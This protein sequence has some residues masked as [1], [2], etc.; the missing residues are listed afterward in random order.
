MPD[1]SLV[2]LRSLLD[3]L[4][5]G[6]LGPADLD[7][8][9]AGP[10]DPTALAG[11]ARFSTERYQR[12]SLYA[13][14]RVE[15]RLLCWGP[16]QSSALHGH[17]GSACAFRVVSGVAEEHLL[18]GALTALSPGAIGKVEQDTI[19]QVA[20]RGQAPL[21]TLHA[22][23]PPLPVDQPAAAD[24]HQVV[25]VGGGLAGVSV[26]VHLLLA[27]GPR[28]RVTLVDPGHEIGR[29]VAYAT[30][31]P[32][33]LLNVPSGKMAIHPD[34]PNA[35]V[36]FALAQGLTA[37]PYTLL[38]RRVYGAYVQQALADA[39]CGAKGRLRLAR[40]AAHTA[41]PSGEGWELRL[42][43]G[44]SLY[45]DDLV[46]ATGHAA[47]RVPAGL[48]ALRGAPGL[49]E[50]PWAPGAIASV[51]ADARVLVVGTGLSAMDVVGSLR[52]QGHRAPVTATSRRGQ[53]PRPHLPD[54]HWTGV[55]IDLDLDAAPATA[56]GLARWL[57]GE[58]KSAATRGIPWQAVLGAVRPHV[59]GL[60]ASLSEAE[61][62][63]FL[64]RHRPRW[65][66]YRHRAP[67]EAHEALRSWRAEGWLR[68][69]AGTLLS[70]TPGPDGLQVIS[71]VGAVVV[72]E[73][74]DY[75]ILCTGNEGEQRAHSP[76]WA[77]LI[78]EGL[79]TPD[80]HGLGVESDHQHGLLDAR[81]RSRRL[82]GIGGMLRPRFFET[83]A[84]PEITAQA[85][86]IAHAVLERPPARL[87]QGLGAVD[88]AAADPAEV[89]EGR[90]QP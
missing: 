53:W 52:R 24:G 70:S 5:P 45:A 83:T 65:E 35:F 80:P 74:Y 36:R 34:D 20:N 82:W 50:D 55:R 54:N 2:D 4:P 21:L 30:P 59:V 13:D 84:A 6:R 18:D 46:L 19:H 15:L 49:I 64:S 37:D 68:S 44:R 10:V 88:P 43:D 9:L 32:E 87:A 86:T 75:V 38:P 67:A 39:V 77:Q 17:G 29:G 73:V 8:A 79:A 66:V 89:G 42:S 58:V 85:Y 71:Q 41:Q 28:L 56:D 7:A 72:D 57:E 40:G 81:G 69:R 76:L 1:P 25:I 61:R 90:V 26:A 31:D 51:P 62:A 78:D 33:H 14:E 11:A 12:V 16:G 47:T 63:R 48:D 3:R 22:Y 23:A 27:G 60:W